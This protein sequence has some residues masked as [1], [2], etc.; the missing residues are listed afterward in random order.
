MTMKNKET[1]QTSIEYGWVSYFFLPT[2][3]GQ[4]HFCVL[5]VRVAVLSPDFF[6][7]GMKIT[8]L[9]DG[10][11]NHQ[12]WV[13]K[14]PDFPWKKLQEGG[15]LN[16]SFQICSTRLYHRATR[17][18]S[19]HWRKFKLYIFQ[20]SS[21]LQRKTIKINLEPRSFEPKFPACK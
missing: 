2:I 21:C 9:S 11:E 8:K 19:G 14:S 6:T 7:P 12:I 10:Y 13:W 3:Y 1:C 16:L 5:P 20:A 18:L 17:V 15:G 4:A